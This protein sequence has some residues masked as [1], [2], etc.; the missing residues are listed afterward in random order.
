MAC[1][2]P[3][4]ACTAGALPEVVGDDG[5]G[6]LVPPRDARALAGAILRLLKDP[7]LRRKMGKNARDRVLKL[8]TWE[9]AA[10][11]MVEVYQEAID[12]HR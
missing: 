2:L 9:K 8:F 11:Q 5:A 6:I 10:R 7:E 3:V 4:V 12:A 1:E